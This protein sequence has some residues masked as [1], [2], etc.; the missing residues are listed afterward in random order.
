MRRA[1][2]Y[3]STLFHLDAETSRP[4]LK[5][6]HPPITKTGSD[7]TITN[8][9]KYDTSQSGTTIHVDAKVSFS[10]GLD[11]GLPGISNIRGSTRKSA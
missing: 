7:V 6:C 10:V 4:D 5:A 1:E 9:S 2:L 8:S 11:K 3:V